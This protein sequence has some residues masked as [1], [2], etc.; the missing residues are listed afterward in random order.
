M[1]LLVAVLTILAV[2]LVTSLISGY[3]TMKY[4]ET[5]PRT[6]PRTCYDGDSAYYPDYPSAQRPT[7]HQ[8]PREL[9]SHTPYEP[10]IPPYQPYPDNPN[11]W[12]RDRW[13]P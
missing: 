4:C 8:W 10:E 5:R 11:P 2:C 12:P 7:G 13:I 1:K 6:D 3:V 9:P